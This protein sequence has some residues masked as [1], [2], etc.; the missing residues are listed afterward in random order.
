[1]KHDVIVIGAG[2]AGL[3][4]ARSLHSAG[5]RVIVL[6]SQNR[7]GGRALTE[8]TEEHPIDLGGQWT[9]PGQLRIRALA[10]HYGLTTYPSHTTGSEQILE[11]TSHGGNG[12]IHRLNMLPH[13]MT[14]LPA[15][16]RL[17]HLVKKTDPTQPW[18]SKIADR[19]DTTTVEEWLETA[20]TSRRARRWADATLREAVST[21]L[22]NIS[23][24]ALANEIASA[25][26]LRST[27]GFEGGAQQDLFV[28]GAD[29]LPT[30]MAA[31]LDVRLDSQAQAVSRSGGSYRVTTSTGVHHMA[32]RIVVATPP[33]LT[34]EIDFEPALPPAQLEA[35]NNL[36]MGS[37][38][39]M[40]AIY[41]RPSWRED[42]KSGMAL[43]PD[44]PATT[45]AD[46]SLSLPPPRR[47]GT[48]LHSGVRTRCGPTLCHGPRHP[49]QDSSGR[50]RTALR[51]ASPNSPDLV[52]EELDR[53]LLGARPLQ[54]APCA[55][56]PRLDCQ[57]ARTTHRR[58]PLGGNGNRPP[59]AGLLR[60]SYRPRKACGN[61]NH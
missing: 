51:T 6:E 8:L 12:I 24:L 35:L 52:G 7:V 50:S 30:L 15:V 32:D 5:M 11:S 61:R 22:G 19:W 20:V 55:W 21:D 39:K 14:L 57:C 34:R 33:P 41:D 42:G 10:D 29:R 4:A 23:M 47:A 3:T 1:M 45:V 59:V 60:R 16:V 49:T 53:G 46:L 9:G 37:V 18:H 28:D 31:E 36:R 13:L 17:H 26:G 38:L 25:G 2:Y 27:M 48:Y 54:C 43:L 44:G 56:N 58:N 40:F